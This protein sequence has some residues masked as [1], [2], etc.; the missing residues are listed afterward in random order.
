[1]DTAAVVQTLLLSLTVTGLYAA[2]ASGL[3]LEWGV[4][5]IINF[6][7][8]EFVMVGA[9]ITYFLNASW[10][11]HPLAGMTVAAVAMG[12]FSALVYKTFLARVLRQAEHNQ[13]LATLGLSILL[14]N[15]AIIL[16]TPN[17]RAMHVPDI[18]PAIR[19]G[20]VTVPGHNV[21][22]ALVGAA[23]YVMLF[24]LMRKTPY[25][26]QMRF[27]SD[28]PELAVYAGVNVERMFGLS[29]VIGGMT[30]GAA[31]GLVALIL[32]VHPLVGLDLAIRAFAIVA[33]GG[34]GNI[35]GALVG[36]AILS[37]VEGLTSTFV[38]GGASWGYGVAFMV[39]VAVLI[40]RPSGLFGRQ[41]RA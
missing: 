2:V 13:L 6:A 26:I 18:V 7:H 4:T 16:W 8:G 29:F 5:R 9:F 35:P 39:L 1:V 36:G 3:T 34:L 31:G 12:A 27:A 30:A 41:A 40:V 38:S 20:G 17:A 22:V 28:D 10:G 11:L 19:L 15:V 24:V 25:G 37:V 14:Q 21:L 32:Y 23:L 33:L